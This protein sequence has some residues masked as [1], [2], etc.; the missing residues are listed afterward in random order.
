[1]GYITDLFNDLCPFSAWA[2]SASCRP[3]WSERPLAVSL[4]SD[5]QEKHAAPAALQEAGQTIQHH[6]SDDGSG[7]RARRG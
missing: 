7:Q 5:F 1:M 4:L 6:G 2:H 3:A